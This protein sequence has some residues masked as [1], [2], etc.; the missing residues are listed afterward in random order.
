[1][2][3]LRIFSRVFLWIL[4]YPITLIFT[5]KNLD[6]GLHIKFLALCICN[7]ILLTY[8]I[9]TRNKY[10]PTKILHSI[11]NNKIV[12]A[13]VA[14]LIFLFISALNS[15]NNSDA[16][17]ELS[18]FISYLVLIVFLTIIYI[19]NQ[20]TFLDQ[21]VKI[22]ITLSF[23][24]V[25]LSL[26]QMI[27]GVFRLGFQNFNQLY[28]V[29]SIFQHRNLFAQILFLSIPYTLYGASFTPTKFWRIFAKVVSVLILALIIILG[30][31]AVWLAFF[32]FFTCILIILVANQNLRK[33]VSTI[34]K[35]RSLLLI[36]LTSIIIS[37]S[38][39]I[40]FGSFNKIELDD[41]YKELLNTLS[42]TDRIELW[43]KSFNLIKE[44]PVLGHGL[45]SWKIEIL[46]FG[47]QGL[48]SENNRTFYQRPH[49][50]YI[51]LL[52]ESGIIGLILYLSIFILLIQSLLRNLIIN[53][54]KEQVLFNLLLISTLLGYLTFSFFSYPKDRV[55][56]NIYI[57]ST[58]VFAIIQEKKKYSFVRLNKT[59]LY[60]II[61]F[62]II[63]IILFLFLSYSRF[64][65]E[66]HIYTIHNHK[67]SKEWYKI[68]WEVDAAK[69]L[70]CKLDQFTAPLDFY[71]GLASIQMGNFSDAKEYL[72]SA[73]N[74]NPY[75][76]DLL[77]NLGITYMHNEEMENAMKMFRKGLQ[78]A[79][80][81]QELNLSLAYAYYLNKDYNDALIQ[82]KRVTKLDSHPI[83]RFL[84]GELKQN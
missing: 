48:I 20:S 24:T 56:Q 30:S 5:Y 64:T 83:Y 49:N 41:E 27:T 16:L 22:V 74:L 55:I 38:F 75:H 34:L 14:F 80:N 37:S 35:S 39:F 2:K 58:I 81:H 18:R 45:G 23:I 62:I 82:L 69:T 59:F 25:S 31:R 17:I 10:Q 47:N 32:T 79:P 15:R 50:D 11:I 65:S 26:F 36:I 66:K 67:N 52:S 76:V 68:H 57:S 63:I 9:I 28:E 21:I 1:M 71:S 3:D 44:A 53:H 70:F 4:F 61:S 12:F 73:I 78:I 43:K 29:H 6:P 42:V 8:L 40:Y 84:I 51:S 54:S 33:S 46:R 19:N 13:Y 7:F 77:N 60:C 72:T